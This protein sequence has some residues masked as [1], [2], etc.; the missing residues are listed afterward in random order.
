MDQTKFIFTLQRMQ[1]ES[2]TDDGNGVVKVVLRKGVEISHNCKRSNR[3]E[4]HFT[5][6]GC[7]FVINNSHTLEDLLRMHLGN[8]N[9]IAPALAF[10]KKYLEEVK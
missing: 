9:F 8:V 10:C 2:V 3:M 6:S 1:P 4:I 7:S 5:D